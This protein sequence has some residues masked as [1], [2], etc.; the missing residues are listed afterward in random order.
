MPVVADRKLPRQSRKHWKLL[1][2]ETLQDISR[3]GVPSTGCIRGHESA[4][5]DSWVGNA[6]RITRSRPAELFEN[7]CELVAGVGRHHPVGTL[8]NRVS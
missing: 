3:S 6:R 8:R 7:V 2:R 1:R 4:L 5:V